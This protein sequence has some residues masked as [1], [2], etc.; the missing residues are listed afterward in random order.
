M[1]RW[2]EILLLVAFACVMAIM[3]WC[4]LRQFDFALAVVLGSLENFTKHDYM[5]VI[6]ETHHGILLS[7]GDRVVLIAPVVVALL[8]APFRLMSLPWKLLASCFVSFSALG[9]IVYGLCHAI[10]SLP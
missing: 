3:S 8:L 7:S 2:L 1:R 4:V 9:A 10:L 6:K 5:S